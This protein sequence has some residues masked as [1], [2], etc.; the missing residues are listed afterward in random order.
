MTGGN[1]VTIRE[2]TVTVIVSGM[3]QTIS[4]DDSGDVF[5]ATITVPQFNTNYSVS[6]TAINSCGLP[7]QPANTTVSI[8]AR[9]KY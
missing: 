2:Y 3:T 7:S 4:H 1:G 6:V 9:G 8:E 5:N